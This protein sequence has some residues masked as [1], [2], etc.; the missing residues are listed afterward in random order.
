MTLPIDSSSFKMEIERARSRFSILVD[1]LNSQD[2]N[3]SLKITVS[4]S[5]AE[6]IVE[7]A[8]SGKYSL[9][10]MMKRKIRNKIYKIFQKSRTEQVIR[11]TGYMVLTF[12][13][14]EKRASKL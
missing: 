6:G 13:I 14:D 11:D 3:A 4:R 8:K 7:E 1:W 2:F 5:A 12:L 10:I 9:I